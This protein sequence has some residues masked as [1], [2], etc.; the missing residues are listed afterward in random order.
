MSVYL[1]P[2]QTAVFN[3]LTSVSLSATVFDDVPGL[4][5]GKPDEDFPYVVIGE[6][7]S[8]AWDT[9]DQEGGRCT[10]QLHVWSR[11]EGK[12]EAKAILGEIDDA[13]HRQAENLTSTGFRYVDCLFE[14]SQVFDQP[15]GK[16]RHGVCRYRVLIEKE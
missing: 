11:Y 14:F 8:G 3:R 10:I 15:D 6:D 5:E 9:D 2:L 4:P 7:T 1:T 13:L 12:K 16:T